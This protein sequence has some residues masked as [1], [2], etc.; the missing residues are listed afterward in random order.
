MLPAFPEVFSIQGRETAKDRL[1][2]LHFQNMEASKSVRSKSCMS[3]EKQRVSKA[4][5]QRCAV[6]FAAICFWLYFDF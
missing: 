6:V 4:P 2:E 3:S 5:S 1:D